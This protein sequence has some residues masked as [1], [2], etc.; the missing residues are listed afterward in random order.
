MTDSK[1]ATG[2]RYDPIDQDRALLPLPALNEDLPVAVS[3]AQGS[4]G[5]TMDDEDSQ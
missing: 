3:G 2:L 5:R 4:N 1:E